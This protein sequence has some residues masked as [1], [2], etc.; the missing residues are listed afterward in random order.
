MPTIV[1]SPIVRIW[2]SGED[3]EVV[4]LSAVDGS[5]PEPEEDGETFEAN[6]RIKAI[7][8]AR[9][10]GAP[11]LADDS[12]LEVDALDGAPGVYI[13]DWAEMVERCRGCTAVAA[14]DKRL[15]GSPKLDA[16]PA[17]CRNKA[18]FADLRST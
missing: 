16:A 18:T 8:S 3:V 1:I 13:A 2:S 14:C 9:A 12:G 11:C 4:G 10:L 17:Y 6:A 15:I 7:A 5:I